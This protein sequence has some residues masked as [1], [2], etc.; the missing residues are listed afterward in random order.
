[1]KHAVTCLRLLE[2]CD[3]MW[4]AISMRQLK[5][6]LFVKRFTKRRDIRRLSNITPWASENLQI[7]LRCLQREKYSWPDHRRLQWRRHSRE[8]T[9][10][11]WPF[12]LAKAVTICR[13]QD[14][15]KKHHH[16]IHTTDLC[17]VAGIAAMHKIKQPQQQMAGQGCGYPAHLRG[18]IDSV[19]QVCI[20][21]HK[22]GNFAKVCRSKHPHPPPNSTY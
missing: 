10:G 18:A 5:D 6:A 19:W 4:M 15:A 14:A 3:A 22:V 21:F 17:G 11:E 12:T 1:M 13:S 7:L 20:S 9:P 16:A 2:L 8:P